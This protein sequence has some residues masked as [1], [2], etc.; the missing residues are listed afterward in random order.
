MAEQEFLPSEAARM[1]GICKEALVGYERLGV[2][3]LRR[4][5]RY[6]V[7]TLADIDT[8]RRHRLT[9]KPGRPPKAKTT[10]P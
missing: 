10:A 1:L 8:I 7:L 9:H 3:T 5:G 2:V 4:V 6:R